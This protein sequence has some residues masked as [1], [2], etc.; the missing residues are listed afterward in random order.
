MWG[1][2]HCVLAVFIA[3]SCGKSPSD[4]SQPSVPSK[5]AVDTKA[6]GADPGAPVRGPLE[7]GDSK[8]GSSAPEQAIR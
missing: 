2:S 1:V 8:V 7:N 6:T 5:S 3:I 4:R